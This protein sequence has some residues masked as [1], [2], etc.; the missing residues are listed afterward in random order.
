METAT[1][2]EK[3]NVNFQEKPEVWDHLVDHSPQGHV[4]LKS[5]FLDSLGCDYDLVGFYEEG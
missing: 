3:Y 1:I 4:F 5:V 2:T